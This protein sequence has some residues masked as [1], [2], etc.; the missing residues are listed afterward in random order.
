MINGWNY[1]IRGNV[2]FD[3]KENPWVLSDQ[4]SIDDRYFIEL[5]KRSYLTTL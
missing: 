3:T 2:V 1:P 5:S 4:I